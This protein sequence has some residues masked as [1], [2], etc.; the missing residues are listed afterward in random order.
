MMTFIYVLLEALEG[1]RLRKVDFW[2]NIVYNFFDANFVSHNKW[3][4]VEGK[5][6]KYTKD[7]NN[8]VSWQV[9][10]LMLFFMFQKKPLQK[11]NKVYIAWNNT[12][13]KANFNTANGRINFI[14]ESENLRLNIN[15]L[16]LVK[17]LASRNPIVTNEIIDRERDQQVSN[18]YRHTY[19]L[20]KY[21]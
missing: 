8:G 1:L 2:R 16:V 19:I 6:L 4:R 13:G 12:L 11:D 3:T 21:K 18:T 5:L 7:L 14:H 20:T 17:L 10:N 15:N 9:Y